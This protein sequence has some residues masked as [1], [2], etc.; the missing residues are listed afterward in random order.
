LAYDLATLFAAS[1]EALGAP[2]QWH[3]DADCGSLQWQGTCVFVRQSVLD[4]LAI[5]SAQLR[6]A[7]DL[8]D[9]A[10]LCGF[11]QLNSELAPGRC[12]VGMDE[13]QLE[14]IR[15]ASLGDHTDPEAFTRLLVSF[16]IQCTA[17]NEYEYQ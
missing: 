3:A 8:T 14:F 11:L 17:I 15:L 13:G 16:V 12:S 9:N 6:V 2:M 10:A 1:S 5:L 4:G 7:P